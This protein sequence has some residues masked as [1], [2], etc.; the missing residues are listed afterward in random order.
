M[1]SFLD[2]TQRH[3]FFVFFPY[4]EYDIHMDKDGKWIMH[5]RLIINIPDNAHSKFIRSVIGINEKDP[6]I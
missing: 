5:E 1:V 2:N 3:S 4:P 6:F